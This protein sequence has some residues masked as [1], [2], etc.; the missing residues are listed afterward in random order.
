M[1][2]CSGLDLKFEK[3]FVPLYFSKKSYFFTLLQDHYT[4][5][6]CGMDGIEYKSLCRFKHKNCK[7]NTTLAVRNYGSCTSD[8][9]AFD[10]PGMVLTLFV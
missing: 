2:V 10:F 5:P 7:E 6:L 1:I 8:Y 4:G 3:V 9:S